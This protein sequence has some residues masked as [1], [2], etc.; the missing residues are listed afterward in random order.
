MAL[1]DQVKKVPNVLVKTAVQAAGVSVGFAAGSVLVNTINAATP[2][3]T[4]SLGNVSFG[5]GDAVLAIGGTL[6]AASLPKIGG[7]MGKMFVEQAVVGAI[8]G[9]GVNKVAQVA[10]RQPIFNNPFPELGGSGGTTARTRALYGGTGASGYLVPSS[11]YAARSAAPVLP[12]RSAYSF[13]VS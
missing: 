13:Q 9:W 7:D 4:V 1:T 10:G 5:I 11:A 12:I 3:Q 8:G 2:Q 6:A